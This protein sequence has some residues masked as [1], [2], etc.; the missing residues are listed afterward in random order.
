MEGENRK[1]GRGRPFL[2]SVRIPKVIREVSVRKKNSRGKKKAQ[3]LV[4]VLLEGRGVAGSR[5][6]ED[7][8]LSKSA[9]EYSPLGIFD[10]RL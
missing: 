9:K 7:G 1:G 10:R 6:T 8:Y 5:K 2:R 4:Q 3:V